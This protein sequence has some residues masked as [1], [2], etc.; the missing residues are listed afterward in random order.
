MRLKK[1]IR[2][3]LS[4]LRLRRAIGLGRNI[5]VGRDFVC[6][7][8]L[9]ISSKNSVAIGDRVFV[10]RYCQIASNVVIGNDV[11]LAS[12]VGLVGG[13]HEIDGDIVVIKNAGRAD[14]RT[15]HI[16][17]GA[18]L[19]HASVVL[20]GVRIGDHSVVAAGAVVTRD[21]APFSVVGGNPARHIR[22][23]RVPGAPVSSTI[24]PN[25]P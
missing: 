13:D 18:W 8:G 5:A 25:N 17:D 1:L 4:R 14:M 22:F 9:L 16:G 6:G 19:G 10:G 11:M 21:V 23:R 20:H 3:I 24:D 12:F 15:T 7:P 2:V